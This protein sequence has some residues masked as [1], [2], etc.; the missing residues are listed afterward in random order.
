MVNLSHPS[1]LGQCRRCH[2]SSLV[3]A[4]DVKSPFEAAR[5]TLKT[6]PKVLEVIQHLKESGLAIYAMSNMSAPDWEF[7]SATIAPEA[8]ALFDQI[9]TLY[10]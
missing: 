6:N 10:A 3:S 1:N 4:V 5:T 9:F 7:V 2:T 8:W